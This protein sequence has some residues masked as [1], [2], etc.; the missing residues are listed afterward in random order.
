[1]NYFLNDSPLL[2]ALMGFFQQLRDNTGLSIRQLCSSSHVSTGTYCKMVKIQA[3]KAECYL[4]IFEGLCYASNREEF[5]EA[6]GKFGDQIYDEFG[7]Q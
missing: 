5:M 6:W 4:R 7:N 1:M 2:R 3:V